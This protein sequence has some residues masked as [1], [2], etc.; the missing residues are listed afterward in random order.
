MDIEAYTQGMISNQKTQV[1]HL[2]YIR[3]GISFDIDRYTTAL[4]DEKTDEKDKPNIKMLIQTLEE[5][6]KGINLQIEYLTN[7]LKMTIP[8]EHNTKDS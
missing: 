8:N 5:E 3:G 7:Y 4:D 2:S 1:R 6:L